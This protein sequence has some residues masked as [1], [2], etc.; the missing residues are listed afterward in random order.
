MGAD[1]LVNY[2]KDAEWDKALLKATDGVGVDV[3]VE[4]GGP[5]TIARSIDS[6]ALNGRRR[7]AQQRKRDRRTSSFF[8]PGVLA[9]N[10]AIKGVTSGSR[11][12]LEQAILAL[13][14]NDVRPVIDRVFPF[15]EAREAY[16]FMT[17]GSHIG[18]V[19]IRLG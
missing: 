6:R 7:L 5:D 4:T 9:K 12:M 3:V 10:L 16:V 15:S 2:A 14:T 18:K 17:R 1:I 8:L 19:V 13:A 11:R